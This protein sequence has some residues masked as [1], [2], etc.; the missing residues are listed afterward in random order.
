MSFCLSFCMCSFVQHLIPLR[1]VYVF[2]L[3]VFMSVCLKVSSHFTKHRSRSRCMFKCCTLSKVLTVYSNT[4]FPEV[5]M[6]I[7]YV[8]LSVF[9]SVYLSF[10]LSICLS[11][12]VCLSVCLSY[13][14]SICVSICLYICLSS[15][16]LTVCLSVCLSL[17][18]SVRPTICLAMI[19]NYSFLLNSRIEEIPA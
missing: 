6:H 1:T 3:Y 17:C 7:I 12:Y 5:N 8:F 16:Y 15:V 4:L 10:R 14:M 11:V 19:T 18:L 13:W 2:P 9:L